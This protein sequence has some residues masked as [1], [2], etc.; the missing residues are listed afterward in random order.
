[1]DLLVL[2]ARSGWDTVAY[3][4]AYW[5]VPVWGFGVAASM[6]ILDPASRWRAWFRSGGRGRGF[7]GT[8]LLGVAS[9]PWHPRWKERL[10][11]CEA[12]GPFDLALFL[13]ASHC[14]TTWFFVLMGPLLGKDVLLSHVVGVG[15]FVL[16]SGFLL[17]LVN[18]D[19]P[20]VQE[21]SA[22][23]GEARP[24][25]EGTLTAGGASGVGSPV[26]ALGTEGRGV[27]VSAAYGLALGS[28][29]AAWGLG[30]PPVL[31]A[32]V[33][34]APWASQTVNACVAVLLAGLLGVPP[35]GNL[36]LGTFL[37]KVGLA[38]A[39]LVAFLT[40]APLSPARLRC[41]GAVFGRD[42]AW[43]LGVVLALSSVAAG[44]LTALLWGVL[45]LEIRYK[46]IPEQMWTS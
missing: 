15:I 16:V 17:G 38:H 43:R 31:P 30:S 25:R 39:G 22:V 27:L 7:L 11:A 40:A 37:W 6:A 4:F 33:V 44:L 14:L 35:V 1:M 13:G 18:K 41:Y 24:S 46:L 21:R 42:R 9:H 12:V 3:L 26:A 34:A 2:A 5:G 36:F 23:T 19:G 20:L 10:S 45:P 28:L 29:V 8:L 32:E